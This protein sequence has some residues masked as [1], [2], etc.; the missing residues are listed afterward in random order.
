MALSQDFVPRREA[1]LDEFVH[2]FDTRITAN[3]TE[4]GLT[5]LQASAFHANVLAWDAAYAVTKNR[6]TRCT[7][8]VIVKDE[9]K[10]LLVKNLRE[11][12][13]IVQAFPATTNELRSLL[14]LTVPCVPQTQP[15]P[16]S[17]PK[18]D[19]LGVKRNVVSVQLRDS[20]DPSRLRPDFAVSANVFSY[21]GENPPATAEGWFFQGGTTRT[22]FDVEFDPSLPMGTKAFL[23]AFFKN[24]RDMSGPACDPVAVTLLGSAALPGMQAQRDRASRKAA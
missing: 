22:R 23:T 16:G 6:A 13:R 15:A 5:A 24:E 19:V 12:A 10:L 11:L 7:Q 4:V 8:A 3:P 14:Q 1:E 21:T 9:K 20:E 2:N 18:I 17:A